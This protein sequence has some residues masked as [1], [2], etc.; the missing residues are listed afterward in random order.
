MRSSTSSRVGE[1]RDHV[2]A[3]EARDLEAL[4]P[5]RAS[6]SIEA[7]LLVG[8]DRLRL[9]LEAVAGADLADA[10]ASGSHVAAQLITLPP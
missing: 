2:G 3:H 1:L 6:R 10:D 4:S 9:V 5:V 8:G 7:D